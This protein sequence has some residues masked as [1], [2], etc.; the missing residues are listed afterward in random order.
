MAVVTVEDFDARLAWY[1]RFLGRHADQHPMD[2]RAEW[3]L[4]DTGVVQLLHDP[5]R[6]GRALLTLG[7]AV[8]DAEIS[9]LA[10]CGLRTG[11]VIEGVIGRIPSISD[12]EGNITD[13]TGRLASRGVTQIDR[14]PHGYP[15]V[16][17]AHLPR[18]AP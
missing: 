10:E 15:V 9:C 6:G 12:P 16:T 5:E 11:E 17:R 18:S 13:A 7:V 4:T 3:R 8:L 1:E 2:G 14:A